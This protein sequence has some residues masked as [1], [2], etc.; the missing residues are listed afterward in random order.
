MGAVEVHVPT[1]EVDVFGRLKKKTTE[2]QY[3]G[4]TVMRKKKLKHVIT[5]WLK[6]FK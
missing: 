2:I 6:Y 1:K 4:R 3:I 5:R